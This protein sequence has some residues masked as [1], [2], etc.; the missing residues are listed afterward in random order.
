MFPD[1]VSF[2]SAQSRNRNRALPFQEPDHRGHRVLGRNGDAHV[3]VVRHQ[4]PFDDLALLLPGQGVENLPHAEA[5]ARK[6]LCAVVWGRTRHGICTPT[7]SGIGFG[8][9][10]TFHPP[11]QGF[12][13]SH[14]GEDVTP[15]RSN[16]F[17]SDWSNQWLT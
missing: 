15:E 9:A 2:L 1:K 12:S 13:S 11:F 7:S 8:K 14:L 5:S 6:S 17:E 16:L 4:M 3:H 10:Q